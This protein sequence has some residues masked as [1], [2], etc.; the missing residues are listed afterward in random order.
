MEIGLD[1]EMAGVDA[2][3]EGQDKDQLLRICQ[4]WDISAWLY[5]NRVIIQAGAIPHSHPVL[6]LNT[7]CLH[8]DLSALGT[9]LHE[10]IHWGVIKQP[11][12]AWRT[13]D[14]VLRQR[15]PSLP[16]TPPEG[17]GSE[18]SNYLH[19]VVNY[20]ELTALAQLVGEDAARANVSERQYYKAIYRIVL[21]D[22]RD[23]AALF[24]GCRAQ[25]S[26]ALP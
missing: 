15:Y 10:E 14:G 9:L 11:G 1:V 3:R 16:L 8:D 5:T 12:S 21:E 19:L 4:R 2:I 23:L 18:R 25:L 26:P 22:E 7:R 6:T 20:F 17:C 24:A 13:L